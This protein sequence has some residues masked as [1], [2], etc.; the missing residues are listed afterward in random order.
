MTTIKT[1][2]AA[3]AIIA[4]GVI[5]AVAIAQHDATGDR[6][7]ASSDRT[8]DTKPAPADGITGG[9]LLGVDEMTPQELSKRMADYQQ[10]NTKSA[11]HDVLERFAGEWDAEVTVWMSGPEGPAMRS[12]GSADSTLILGGKYLS[13]DFSS[14]MMGQPYTG[15][16]VM[17]YDNQRKLFFTFWIDSMGTAPYL[18]HG[19]LSQDGRTITTIGP[20]DEPMTGEVGKPVM[21][22]TTWLGPDRYVTEAKEVV[23]GEPFTVMRIEYMRAE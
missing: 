9:D 4:A 1:S 20:M 6:S 13:T 18:S 11:G 17:G 21:W 16:A 23:Y 2:I 10:M 3:H 15:K 19:S 5:G 22:T 14:E 7:S 8:E 12:D